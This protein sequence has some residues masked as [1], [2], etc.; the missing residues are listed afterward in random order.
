MGNK[1]PVKSHFDTCNITPGAGMIK[2]IGRASSL[3]R[4]L[5]LETLLI[6]QIKPELNTKDEFRSRELT[7]ARNARCVMRC[8]YLNATAI[9]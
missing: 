8:A 9:V 2:I 3:P 6:K 7:L 5:T 1:G 4:L